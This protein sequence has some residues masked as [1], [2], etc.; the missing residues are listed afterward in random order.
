MHVR[1]SVNE[2]NF[3]TGC[4][5]VVLSS[6]ALFGV[7]YGKGRGENGRSFIMSNFVIC[8]LDVMLLG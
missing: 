4:G 1:A 7:S 2:G 5:S 8:S 3:L 6:T